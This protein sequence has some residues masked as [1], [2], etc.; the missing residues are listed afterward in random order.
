ML[1]TWLNT[2][3]KESVRIES[4]RI[5]SVRMES[6]RIGRPDL[7]AAHDVADVIQDQEASR[8]LPHI[9]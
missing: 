2:R 5:G 7:S 1:P 4:V 3:K 9:G 8:V 6:V